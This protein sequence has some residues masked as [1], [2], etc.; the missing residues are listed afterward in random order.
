[1]LA[2][3]QQSKIHFSFFFFSCPTTTTRHESSPEKK[4]KEI[5]SLL[6]AIFVVSTSNRK[7][8]TLVYWVLTLCNYYKVLVLVVIMR[9]KRK[10]PKM[11]WERV[12][13]FFFGVTFSSLA[14]TP[15]PP[16]TESFQKNTKKR[17]SY[18]EI[19]EH[20]LEEDMEWK[21]VK[22]TLWVL[23]LWR[24]LLPNDLR[25]LLKFC[26]FFFFIFL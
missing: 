18:A 4:W 21:I 9:K 7:S 12:A 11:K 23:K 20:T 15:A 22:F 14:S 16:V 2:T 3:K 24:K 26:F 6:A 1:M 5:V 25:Q 10:Y 13:T 19:H 17:H 8:I